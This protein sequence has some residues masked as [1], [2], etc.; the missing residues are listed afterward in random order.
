MGL[1]KQQLADVIAEEIGRQWGIDITDNLGD[2]ESIIYLGDDK[3][4][5]I[6]VME[7][8]E[9]ILERVQ[10]VPVTPSAS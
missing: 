8:A 7:L 5:A 9:T 1:N 4:P 2:G 6:N 10:G 3:L